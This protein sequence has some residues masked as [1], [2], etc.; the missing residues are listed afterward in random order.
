MKNEKLKMKDE[1]WNVVNILEREINKLL[2]QGKDNWTYT[3]AIFATPLSLC[4]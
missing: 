3:L 4:V 2:L 1:K